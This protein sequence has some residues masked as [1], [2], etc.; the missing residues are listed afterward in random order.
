MASSPI[1]RSGVTDPA[2][3]RFR[4]AQAVAPQDAESLIASKR[5]TPEKHRT[6]SLIQSKRVT[7]KKA[8]EQ[9]QPTST[10]ALQRA[11]GLQGPLEPSGWAPAP[12]V[13]SWMREAQADEAYNS[14]SL[15]DKALYNAGQA[16]TEGPFATALEWIMKPLTVTAVGTRLLVENVLR[17]RPEEGG[18]GWGDAWDK[19]GGTY[20]FGEILADYNVWQEP[21]NMKWARAVGFAGDVAFDPLTWLGLIGKGLGI[22]GKLTQQGA[23]TVSTHAVRSSITKGL[24]DDAAGV[25]GGVFRNS[26]LLDDDVTGAIVDAVTKGVDNAKVG[27]KHTDEGVMIDLGQA[28]GMRGPQIDGQYIHYLDDVLVD[29]IKTMMSAGERVMRRGATAAT[30]DEIRILGKHIADN[31]LDAALRSPAQVGTRAVDD[32]FKTKNRGYKGAWLDPS[33]VEDLTFAF[34]FRVPF[35]GAL[36]KKIFRHNFQQPVGI[37]FWGAN[38]R[39]P[40][41]GTWIRGVPQAA[42]TAAFGRNIIG[43]GPI[44]KIAQMAGRAA[45]PEKLGSGY[46]GAIGWMKRGGR[47]PEVRKLLRT[48]FEQGDT[49]GV[50]ANKAL[51]HAAGRGD[52]AGRVVR[53]QMLRQIDSF[54]KEADV[55]GANTADLYHAIAGSE[56]AAARVGQDLTAKGRELMRGLRK[57]A[58]EKAG[59]NFLGESADYVPRILSE[60]GRQHLDDK[61]RGLVNKSHRGHAFEESGFEKTRKYISKQEFEELV[62]AEILKGAT[63][64]EAVA[65]VRASGRQS[66]FLGEQLYRPGTEMPASTAEAPVIA[67]D[68][69]Q[70]VAD[71]MER[72][73]INYS[74]FDEDLRRAL[75][76]YVDAISK[77][78]GE[79]YIDTLMKKQGIFFDATSTYVHIPDLSSTVAVQKVRQ[80][81]S[82]VQRSAADLDNKLK[83]AVEEFGEDVARQTDAVIEAEAV[84]AQADAAYQRSLVEFDEATNAYQTIEMQ[85]IEIETQIAKL[86]ARDEAVR[87]EMES[88]DLP[89]DRYR[90]LEQERQEIVKQL[91]SLYSSEAMFA[92][93]LGRLR[94]A[95]VALLT[96][97]DKAYSIFGNKETFEKFAT[98]FDSYVDGTVDDYAIAAARKGEKGFTPIHGD[99]V[100]EVPVPDGEGGVAFEQMAD[101]IG[102]ELRVGD[103]VIGSDEATEMLGN[104]EALIADMDDSGLASWLGLELHVRADDA[105]QFGSSI[106]QIGAVTKILEGEINNAIPLLE[107]GL[108]RLGVDHLIGSVPSPQNVV[109]A[110]QV[111]RRKIAEQWKA[112]P[113]ADPWVAL[114]GDDD[115][116][117]AAATFYGTYGG[118]R[119]ARGV[120][121]GTDLDELVASARVS[122]RQR[123]Q[124]IE[125][126]LAGAPTFEA[127]DASG[128]IYGD[129]TISDV[130]YL[131]RLQNGIR[132]GRHG[133]QMPF[134]TENIPVHKLFADGEIVDVAGPWKGQFDTAADE[135]SA[136]PI[137]GGTNL[138]FKIRYTQADG[139]T[140][141]YYAKRYDRRPIGTEENPFWIVQPEEGRHR[142][143]GEVLADRLYNDIGGGAPVS[144]YGATDDTTPTVGA[145]LWKVS[146]IE[147][148]FVQGLEQVP[149]TQQYREQLPDG[150]FRIVAIDDPNMV[151]PN[152]HT[153]MHELVGDQMATD[154]LV[155]NHDAVG[156]NGDNI[157]I[158]R[159]SGKIM[160]LDNGA[161]FHYRAQGQRKAT[162]GYE[163]EGVS[164]FTDFFNLDF[165]SP[166]GHI[167]GYRAFRSMLDDADN[168]VGFA[169]EMSRQVERL[170]AVRAD[171]GG[172]EYWV[173][174]QLPKAPE[175]DI[176]MYTSWLETRTQVMAERFELPYFTGDDLIG[177]VLARRGIP[178][179]EIEQALREGSAGAVLRL[180]HGTGYDGYFV[181]HWGLGVPSSH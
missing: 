49:V 130:V 28:A 99:Q 65:N 73:G 59:Q 175:E 30:D 51:L 5:L 3:F 148:D 25:L 122:L 22:A 97:E 117:N 172:W 163:W 33:E 181:P 31:Q 123:A 114:M 43:K 13:Q 157:G 15:K 84:L 153:P 95:T 50:Y 132:R 110:K 23:R 27:V 10:N 159:L 77:R 141:Y 103:R 2:D 160:R 142:V 137:V 88:G 8:V 56:E 44:A 108:R 69:E 180:V 100:M 136:A 18:L 76:V 71:I 151:N 85:S 176:Q 83:I 111:I 4:A 79:V 32:V 41:I 78:T 170:L 55:A 177:E 81:A 16:M 80:A 134:A 135:G 155:G 17:K 42:R 67:Q 12:I 119:I 106:G 46:G 150:T 11:L 115:F 14:L 52:L 173:R 116:R 38:T 112:D 98:A 121:N 158:D 104:V 126:Q 68:V 138:G 62:D 87:F 96:L 145:G 124:D 61:G 66:D 174:K 143:S 86:E 154:I 37:K 40:L 125:T 105:A 6:E 53:Q 54:F 165:E 91:D 19:I 149:I 63:P 9:R 146:E 107:G 75:E 168:T 29:E 58:N 26:R 34:G 21:E 171:N 179:N 45:K 72:L 166:S 144:W 127:H 162:L 139:T 39:T 128:M 64:Q 94:G 47:L 92:H 120:L 70:Q 1:Q 101:V 93:Q 89:F 161:V 152:V 140:R 113:S 36:G 167:A 24:G 60:K 35:T 169:G 20:T 102:W 129:L 156:F 7:P 164:E 131:M 82:T 57:L 133:P 118:E 48:A 90:A 147:E 178:A 74:L 109:A